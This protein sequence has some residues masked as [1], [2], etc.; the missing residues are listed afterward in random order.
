MRHLSRDG[1]SEVEVRPWSF[2]ELSMLVSKAIGI[3]ETIHDLANI[4]MRMCVEGGNTAEEFLHE[5]NEV[6]E[7]LL[8]TCDDV[9][10][11]DTEDV[12]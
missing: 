10:Y 7:P 8:E 4:A 5:R 6:G 11:V 12:V 9:A 1:P 2:H 3:G